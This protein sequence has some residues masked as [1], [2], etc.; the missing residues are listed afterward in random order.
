M[1][2]TDTRPGD[3]ISQL[4]HEI[5]RHRRM[6]YLVNNPE[7][8]DSEYDALE[9]ELEHLKPNIR[10]FAFPGHLH[11]SSAGKRLWHLTAFNTVLP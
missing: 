10:I 3:R 1:S 6:Y 4:T 11:C 9:R 5:L 7:I 8:S 2:N